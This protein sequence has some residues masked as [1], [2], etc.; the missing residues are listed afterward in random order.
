M[1]CLTNSKQRVTF[2]SSDVSFELRFALDRSLV[3]SEVTGRIVL[4]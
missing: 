2:Y 1:C 4:S 3:D